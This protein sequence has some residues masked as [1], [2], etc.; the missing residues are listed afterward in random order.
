M[1]GFVNTLAFEYLRA[2]HHARLFKFRP[3]LPGRPERRDLIALPNLVL[4]TVIRTV[5]AAYD[6]T[7]PQAALGIGIDE[8]Q[9]RGVHAIGPVFEHVL[10]G[11][12]P[13]V[14]IDQKAQPLLIVLLGD[15]GP[16]VAVVVFMHISGAGIVMDFLQPVQLAALGLG[17]FALDCDRFRRLDQRRRVAWLCVLFPPVLRKRLALIGLDNHRP[18]IIATG[19]QVPQVITL[20]RQHRR[21]RLETDLGHLVGQLIQQRLEPRAGK[22]ID[23]G[24]VMLQQSQQLAAGCF[25]IDVNQR[26]KWRWRHGCLPCGFSAHL[27]C[28]P[29]NSSK[30]I[31]RF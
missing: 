23:V 18:I 21:Q 2:H 4:I 22:H 13:L 11:G 10:L 15:G 30:P 1:L 16:T 31:S 24:V 7:F 27:S 5:I 26:I 28:T 6:P 19:I 20:S 8:L 3:L 9:V 14:V 29:P 17:F 12:R 25:P